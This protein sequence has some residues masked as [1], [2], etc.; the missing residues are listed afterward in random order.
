MNRLVP[1]TA[2][3]VLPALIAAANDNARRRFFEFLHGQ[4]SK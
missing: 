3:G 1:F 4:H 2:D